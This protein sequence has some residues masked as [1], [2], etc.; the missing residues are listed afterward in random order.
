MKLRQLASAVILATTAVPVMAAKYELTVVPVNDLAY[1][2]FA[3]SIDESGTL[4][5][6]LDDEF[7][8]DIDLDL[9]DFDS[10][11]FNANFE[12]ATA[13]SQG[14]FSNADYQYLYTYLASGRATTSDPSGDVTIQR[15]VQYRSY[16]TDTV[17]YDLIPGFDEI[18]EDFAD[19]SRSSYSLV[20]DSLHGDY[21]VGTSTTPFETIEYNTDDGTDYDYV[22]N[23]D[24]RHAFVEVNGETHSLPP[25]D[26]LDE[27]Y[28][29]SDAYAINDNLQIA[30]FGSA[31]FT[32][33]VQDYLD[34]CDH[35]DTRG[36]VPK[37]YCI[38]NILHTSSYFTSLSQQR[39]IV[40]QI[41]SSGSVITT[42]TYDL[43]FE[44][45][46]DDDTYYSSRALAINS[47]GI[48]VGDS[49][50]GETEYITR[51]SSSS[52]ESVLVATSF[53]EG[54]TTELLPRVESLKSGA[55]D[56]NDNNWIVGYVLE[57]SNG[58]A[59]NQM[60]IYNYDDGET[61][62]PEG[63]FTSAAVTAHAINNN[64]I[65]V[66]YGEYDSTV[67]TNREV[68]AFMY[69]MEDEDFIDLNTYL[70]CDDASTYTLV[71]AVDINDD[72]EII[73]NARIR[74]PY[75]YINGEEYIDSDGNTVEVDKIV[76]VKLTP[77]T[78][79]EIDECTIEEIEDDDDY[80]R[81]GASWGLWSLVSL[82]V[83][84]VWRRRRQQ[85]GK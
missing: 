45:D 37:E 52:Y 38:Y 47:D 4:V 57:E 71:D 69:D 1:N 36:D 30:G 67:E 13:V 68:R 48:A 34:T 84:G 66:G 24:L 43:V 39:A 12:D 31:S 63:F 10:T 21:F 17:G 76:A 41:D 2:N 28:G 7:N 14:V 11:S 77:V 15:L 74:V 40:W 42:D 46:D 56:I 18:N 75:T 26:D 70:D 49:Q 20:R 3:K 8:P 64:N 44:P 61:L 35:Y 72:N 5:V 78:G 32:D 83:A 79:G 9:L 25:D 33:D 81:Q 73:A 22:V 50:T 29:Y 82:M 60:F 53:Y 6:V 51:E 55:V 62:Y 19:Y 80:E 16:Q 23:S 54:E 59:R 65:I 58:V 27:D 85:L